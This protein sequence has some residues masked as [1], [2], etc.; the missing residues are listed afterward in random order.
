MNRWET[1]M[2]SCRRRAADRAATLRN[3]AASDWGQEPTL[4]LDDERGA[5]TVERI[6]RTWIRALTLASQSNADLVLLV[7]DDVRFAPRLRAI[8][9]NWGPLKTRARLFFGSLFDNLPSFHPLAGADY[10]LAPPSAFWG[11][12][13]IVSTPQTLSEIL[14]RIPAACPP[15]IDEC[16]GRSIANLTPIYVHKPGLVLH[17]GLSTRSTFL[18]VT[19]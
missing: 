10:A 8:V 13:A 2:V 15:H 4:V 16:I 5:T 14:G 3:L 11:F 9:E 19:A 12:Q 6:R 7:E 17:V 18:G 1:F